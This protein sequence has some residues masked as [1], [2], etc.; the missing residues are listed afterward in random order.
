MAPPNFPQT[1]QQK[2]NIHSPEQTLALMK[3]AAAGSYAREAPL[4]RIDESRLV[5]GLDRQDL[6]ADQLSSNVLQDL[7]IQS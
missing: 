4:K 1:T 7:H 5:V 2:S 3:P 6:D